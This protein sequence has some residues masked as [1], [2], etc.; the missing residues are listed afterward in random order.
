MLNTVSLDLFRTRY[1]WCFKWVAVMDDV[2]ARN[3]E[4]VVESQREMDDIISFQAL[5]A[6]VVVRLMRCPD[7]R[8]NPSRLAC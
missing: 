4:Q 5:V 7:D 1:M 3:Y 8:D 6:A 2:L